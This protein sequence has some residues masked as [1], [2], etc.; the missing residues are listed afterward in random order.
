MREQDFFRI[1]E[2]SP[3]LLFRYAKCAKRCDILYFWAVL[4]SDKMKLKIT[5]FHAD[6]ILEA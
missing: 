5:A 2:R 1:G 6:Q 3:V 4:L